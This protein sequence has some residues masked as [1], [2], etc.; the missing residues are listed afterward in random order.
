VGGDR[1]TGTD[2][3][4]IAASNKDLEVGV[5]E[6]TFRDDLYYWINIAPLKIPP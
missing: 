4:N 5:R 2:A 6:A 1:T 3:R